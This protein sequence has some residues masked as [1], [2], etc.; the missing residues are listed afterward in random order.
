M[1]ILPDPMQMALNMVP[2]LAAVFGMYFIILKPLIAYL[3]ERDAAIEGGR[4]EAEEIEARIG[5]KMAT[6]EQQL[7]T[8][9]ADVATLRNDQRAQ[10][11]SAYDAV[12]AQARTAAEAEINEAVVQISATRDAA[13]ETLKASSE[14]LATQ[15]AGQVLGRQVASR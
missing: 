9:K 1:S 8:A 15:V 14:E 6:Y 5:E 7:A 12:I 3:D 2:F 11:Q 13:A 4:A 10:A